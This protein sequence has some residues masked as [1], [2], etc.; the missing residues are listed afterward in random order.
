MFF[1]GCSFVVLFIVGVFECYGF[2]WNYFVVGCLVVV[3]IFWDV[4]DRDIDW[5]VGWV[6]EE[7]GFFERGIFKD[8]KK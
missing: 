7:W 2:V 5:F 8:E 3:G 1:M 4:M 6:F